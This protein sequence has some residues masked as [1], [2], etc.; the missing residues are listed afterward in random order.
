MARAPLW[1]EFR[2]AS[3]QMR[4]I[5][6]DRSQSPAGFLALTASET[7]L[8]Y[9]GLRNWGLT[10]VRLERLAKKRPDPGLAVLLSVVFGALRRQYRPA[11]TLV[12]QAVRAAQAWAGPP[13]GRFVNAILR[14][15]LADPLAA[16]QDL[17]H[18]IARW[19][20]PQWWIDRM[21]ESL[22]PRTAAWL[23]HQQSAPP[24]TVRFIGPAEQRAAWI[25]ALAS[26][27]IT[28]WSVGPALPQ[29]FHLSPAR[30]VTQLPGF[31]EGWFRVQDLSAQRC[32]RIL[33]PEPG[34]SVWDVCAAP[35]GKTFLMAEKAQLRVFATDPSVHRL[36]RLE[37]EW[38]RVRAQLPAAIEVRALDPGQTA[39]WPKDWPSAFDHLILDLPCSASGVV[40]RHPEIPWKRTPGQLESLRQTQWEILQQAWRRLKP[41]G[42]AL[43]VTCS[44]FA[45]EGEQLVQ[46][47][48]NAACHVERLTAPGLMI[49]EG[50]RVGDG[51]FV[52]RLR[53]TA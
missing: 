1:R 4:R 37:T 10:Q 48:Q 32:A 17:H 30:P 8:L 26:E 20:A 19:N 12:D 31:D 16:A 34:Q 39:D 49:A 6:A 45:Q 50:E 51:F 27:G 44:V 9:G 18:P 2:Q 53:R 42:Q 7:D 33:S 15:T 14:Q 43:L 35:G 52:A 13:G 40:R 29:A 46:R 36:Q 38:V 41:G 5:L 3:Q 21:Q 47:W 28:A 24:L 23:D 22:G 25:E 11:A